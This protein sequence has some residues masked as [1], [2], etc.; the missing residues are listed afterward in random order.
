M[1]IGILTFHF[2][3]NY[4]GVLQAYALQ[5]TLEEMGYDVEIIDYVPSYYFKRNI[6]YYIGLSRTILGILKTIISISYSK[7]LRSSFDEFRSEFMTL[8]SRINE[9]QLHTINN[10][11]DAIIVG[12]DQ[13]WNWNQHDKN[14]Y[15][16][17][18]EPS[19]AG[20]RISYAPCC[21][22]NRISDGC[23]TKL[24]KA[25]NAFTAI[26]VRNQETQTFVR[27]LINTEPPIVADPTILY[28]FKEFTSPILDADYILAYIIGKE[29]EGGNA[30][31]IKKL[32]KLYP[33]CLVI[34]V[35]TC[36]D[37][38]QL[39]TWA[40]K[41]IYN[42]GP[43]EWVGLIANAKCVFTD[44]FHG[45]IFSMKYKRDFVCFYSETHRASRFIDMGNR[46]KIWDNIIRSVMELGEKNRK[47]LKCPDVV[48]MV[49]KKQK[50]YSISFLK[51]SLNIN[52]DK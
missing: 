51:N 25:L 17:D 13:V 42:A 44:S 32:K 15:F 33:K 48:D 4:G 45:T 20:L 34:G 19:F 7:K 24:I 43:A 49:F 21:A 16:I 28:D 36:F 40:D 31:A 14:A 47:N 1:K 18:W 3:C 46:Y 41:I 50:D 8:S 52:K 12:S 39:M 10:L 9:K 26:S 38:P 30:N 2:S 5:K 27:D 22:I 6:K 11:Y 35:Q 23:R 37:N 29:I